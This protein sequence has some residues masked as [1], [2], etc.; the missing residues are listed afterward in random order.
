MAHET[1]IYEPE[2]S[3]VFRLNRDRWGWLSN[4]YPCRIEVNDL[5]GY[6]SEGLYQAA[7]FPNRPDVQRSVMAQRNPMVSKRTAH[8]HIGLTRRDWQR[9]TIRTMRWALRVKLAQNWEEFGGVLR[10]TGDSDIVEHSLRDGFWGADYQD[11]KLVGVNALGRLLMELRAELI[12]PEGDDLK[13][14]QAPSIHGFKIG[15]RPVGTVS[16][17]E[18]TSSENGETPTRVVN[19][20]FTRDYDLYIG[21]PS[22]YGRGSK[23]QNPFKIG[24]D[25]TRAKVLYL[26]ENRVRDG[27]REKHFTLEF[28]ANVYGKVVGCF[29]A[30][31]PCHGDIWAYYGAWAFEALSGGVQAPPLPERMTTDPDA[32]QAAMPV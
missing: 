17:R 13:V 9:T 31:E 7:R 12:G 26:F 28:V 3:T 2:E 16:V 18:P 29:C 1:R 4:F 5:R 23:Y 30:P 21:R 8:N 20:K 25:G 19:V 11:G 14:V 22:R 32:E 15:G 10:E 24:K 6:H 27:I